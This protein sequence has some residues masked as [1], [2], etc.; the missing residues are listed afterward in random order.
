MKKLLFCFALISIF[1]ITESFSQQ[2]VYRPVNPNFGG[3]TFNY[4]FLLS[5]AQA[6]NPF[7][8]EQDANLRNQQSE[9]EAFTENLNNQLLNQISRS[10][11]TQQFGADGNLTPGT[12]SFGSLVVEIF[13]SAE[14]LVIDIL[15]I[16]NGDQTQIIIPGN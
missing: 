3:D 11:F 7:S 8:E 15:D 2:L 13:E 12:F 5:S 1:S 9:I 14:G 6:Q 10:L 16:T 4:Q